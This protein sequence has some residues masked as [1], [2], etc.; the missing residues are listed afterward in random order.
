MH[1]K[2]VGACSVYTKMNVSESLDASSC[3]MTDF[4]LTEEG[5]KSNLKRGTQKSVY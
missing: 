1:G 4:I 3:V 2:I 5:L